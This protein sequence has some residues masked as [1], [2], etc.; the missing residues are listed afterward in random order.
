YSQ[1]I[2]YLLAKAK[3]H[4]NELQ[5]LQVIFADLFEHIHI[6]GILPNK[7]QT[8]SVMA[9]ALSGHAVPV[10]YPFQSF[11]FNLNVT[12][13]AYRD[14]MDCKICLVV[15]VVIFKGGELLKIHQGCIISESN[16]RCAVSHSCDL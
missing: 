4:W 3:L 11:V 1:L 14:K 8:L 12:T 10:I 2:L 15:P 9:N 5:N 16:V 7:Y 13:E 6:A